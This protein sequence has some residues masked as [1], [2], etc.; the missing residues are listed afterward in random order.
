MIGRLRNAVGWA[1]FVLLA[2]PVLGVLMLEG[3]C[4]I[5]L[6]ACE[7]TVAWILNKESWLHTFDRE[8]GDNRP[9]RWI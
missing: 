5:F 4:G 8:I 9:T 2:A 1:V 7:A 3:C 6:A